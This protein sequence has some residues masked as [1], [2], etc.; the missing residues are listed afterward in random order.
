M[1]A[2]AMPRARRSPA[3]TSA[4]MTDSESPSK[5][6]SE[7]P[8]FGRSQISTC[9]SVAASARAS[10]RT[11]GASLLKRPPGVMTHG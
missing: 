11:P 6:T 5:H 10:S 3:S 8:V 2:G 7:A 1:T 9:F 4:C